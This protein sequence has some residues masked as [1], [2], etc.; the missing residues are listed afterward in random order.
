MTRLRR[1]SRAEG[2]IMIIHRLLLATPV[3]LL[4][5]LE[6]GCGSSREVA[7]KG[8]VGSNAAAQVDGPIAVQ[9]FDVMDAEK[10]LLVHSIKLDKLAAFDAKASLQGDEVLVRAI[11]DRDDNGACSAGEP[12]AEVRV[13]VKDDDTVDTVSLE[14]NLGSCPTE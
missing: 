8:Q 5:C 7:I 11:N 14:L 1:V 12:W 10:P 6:M 4:L 3:A 13:P 9:F 2:G